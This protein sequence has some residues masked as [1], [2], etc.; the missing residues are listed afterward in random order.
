MVTV[1][2]RKA[3]VVM[4]AAQNHRQSPTP[5]NGYQSADHPDRSRSDQPMTPRSR[6]GGLWVI[7]VT[8]VLLLLLLLI[9]VLQNGQRVD[10]S[11]LGADGNVPLG[12]A[13]LLAAVF[14]ALLVALPG[15]VR[16]VQLR[17]LGRRRGSLLTTRPLTAPVSV[18]DAP[19]N[20]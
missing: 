1:T 12:V 15:T 4:T 6:A 8:F 18:P 2:T 3:A 14:G 11:F 5:A 20:G 19:R 13:L 9:F 10:V 7:A 16:I 17:L